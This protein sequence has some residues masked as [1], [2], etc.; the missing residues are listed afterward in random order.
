MKTIN[1]LLSSVLIFSAGF[2]SA[3]CI[4]P[5]VNGKCLG[6]SVDGYNSG[7]DSYEGSS[8]STYQYDL[9]NGTDSNRYS[10]DLDAQ[11]RDQ[12]DNSIDSMQDRLHG[13]NGGGIY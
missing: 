4:G 7:S 6:A 8:G 10:L 3:G 2:A 13:Q 11:R 1:I 5:V 9:N 12:M